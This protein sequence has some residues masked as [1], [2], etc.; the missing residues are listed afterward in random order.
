MI[1]HQVPNSYGNYNYNARIYQKPRW[2]AH[3]HGNYE[4]IYAISGETDVLLNDVSY[5][6]LPGELI[7]ISPYTVHAFTG[8]EE[9]K[10]WVG[11]FSEDY[12][13]AFAERY[14]SFSFA[15]FRCEAQTEEWLRKWL[16]CEE[17]PEHYC[18]IS[19]LYMVCNECVR[20]AG[21][22]VENTDHGFKRRVITYVSEHTAGDLSMA[23]LAKEMGYEYHYFSALF[24]NCFCM[25]FKK[26]IHLFRFEAACRLLA[27]PALSITEISARSG[28]GSMRNFNRVFKQL[29]GLSPC[30]YRRRG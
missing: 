2:Y 17:K 5:R 9:S 6:L 22:T 11:V 16:F 18:L 20:E 7:L 29:S 14:R 10:I 4:L 25:D 3:F 13:T 30:E 28:F 15:K 23:V 1:F 26:F 12:V 21:C 19:C 27:D 8:G 24:H